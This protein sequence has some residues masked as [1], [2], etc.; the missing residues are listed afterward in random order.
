MIWLNFGVE[1][2][3]PIDQYITNL[4]LWTT[5]IRITTVNRVS[6][7]AL[8]VALHWSTKECGL[9]L[10]WYCSM[11]CCAY[12]FVCITVWAI[13]CS[14][15]YSLKKSC[16]VGFVVRGTYILSSPVNFIFLGLSGSPGYS[17]FHCHRGNIGWLCLGWT[18]PRNPGGDSGPALLPM[19]C[20]SLPFP[21]RVLFILSMAW[22]NFS[23]F[24]CTLLILLRLLQDPFLHQISF[25]L[26]F[27]H[28]LLEL[29]FLLLPLKPF[30]VVV[31]SEYVTRVRKIHLPETGQHLDH[32]AQ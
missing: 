10:F 1:I 5:P 20:W 28:L 26:F 17:L 15:M 27:F 31:R 18:Y 2:R 16:A 22:Q 24:F 6:I 29:V 32:T 14:V 9:R 13:I 25:S 30:V 7:C 11:N 3:L 8:S 21:L 12:R 23:N 19:T 4:G